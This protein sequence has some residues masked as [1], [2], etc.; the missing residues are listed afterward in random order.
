M[1]VIWG[2]YEGYMGAFSEQMCNVKNKYEPW[3][4]GVVGLAGRGSFSIYSGVSFRMIHLL[5]KS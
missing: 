2:L 5:S 1:R 4:G 3:W